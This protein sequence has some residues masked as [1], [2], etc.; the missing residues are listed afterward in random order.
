MID[1]TKDELEEILYCVTFTNGDADGLVDKIQ[2]MINSYPE[3]CEHKWL[4]MA[5]A[6][7]QCEKCHERKGFYE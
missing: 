7:Q 1:F 4:N 2:S 5:Y 6:Y 3:S